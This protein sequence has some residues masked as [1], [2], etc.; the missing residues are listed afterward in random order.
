MFSSIWNER[1]GSGNR[2]SRACRIGTPRNSAISAASSGCALPENTFS[3]PNPIGMKGS[4]ISGASS[5]W[6]GR[7]DSNL[8]IRDPK[9]RALPLGHAPKTFSPLAS[10]QAP[11]RLARQKPFH[12]SPR[13]RHR[14][15]SHYSATILT[16]GPVR[17]RTAQQSQAPRVSRRRICRACSNE[18]ATP[19]TVGPLP[20]ISA[21]SAPAASSAARIRPIGGGGGPPPPPPPPCRGGRPRPRARPPPPPP[22][23]P[24]GRAPPRRPRAAPAPAPPRRSPHARR[25]PPPPPPPPPPRPPPA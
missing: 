9:S 18:R 25:P 10:L 23:A 20:D 14:L 22:R 12:R 1:S 16:A 19:N 2:R 17:V 24:P 5:G 11:A 15:G 6:L 4:P 3:S 13:R 21:P 7:E 8:R